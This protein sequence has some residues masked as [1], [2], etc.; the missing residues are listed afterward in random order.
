MKIKSN[1][2][3]GPVSHQIDV[4]WHVIDTSTLR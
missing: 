4:Y 2:K 3:A 1:V